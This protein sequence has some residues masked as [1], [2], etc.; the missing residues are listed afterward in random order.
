[1]IYLSYC[2]FPGLIITQSITAVIVK[3]I[4]TVGVKLGI[5]CGLLSFTHYITYI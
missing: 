2:S 1:M 3:R 5:Y 4:T